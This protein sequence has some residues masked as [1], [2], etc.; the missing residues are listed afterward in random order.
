MSYEFKLNNEKIKKVR[1]Y[2]Q[3][4]KSQLLI[5]FTCQG[6]KFR[7]RMQKTRLISKIINEIKEKHGIELEEIVSNVYVTKKR[8]AISKLLKVV[9]EIE[10][11]CGKNIYLLIRNITLKKIKGIE[12]DESWIRTLQNLLKT[13]L[14]EDVKKKIK[15]TIKRIKNRI[16]EK[17]KGSKALRLSEAGT[18]RKSKTY[19]LVMI[20]KPSTSLDKRSKY[21]IVQKLL[22]ELKQHGFEVEHVYQNV[23]VSKTKHNMVKLIEAL[24]ICRKYSSQYN[25]DIVIYAGLKVTKKHLMLLDID[26]LVEITIKEEEKKLTK[27]DVELARRLLEFLR[28]EKSVRK[29]MSYSS[30]L[31]KYGIHGRLIEILEKLLEK[32]SESEV[33]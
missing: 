12:I 8:H 30:K 5:I 11:K 4:R 23:Y 3:T 20:I 27:E 10:D 22:K 17:V 28:T 14:P 13:E 31:E 1:E 9:K 21:K 33:E 2:I 25:L 16:S 24:S 32:I 19:R 29:A 26:K 7:N 6:I 18:L 15:S